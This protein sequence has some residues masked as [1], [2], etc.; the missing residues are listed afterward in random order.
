MD[1]LFPYTTRFRAGGAALSGDRRQERAEQIA[2]RG[3]D[4]HAGEAG[5]ARGGRDAR[6][7][8]D[9]IDHLV[10][11]QRTRLRI[12]AEQLEL[13][14]RWRHRFARHVPR[15]LPP[16][17]GGL[18]PKMLAADHPVRAD[19]LSGVWGQGWSVLVDLCGLAF[20]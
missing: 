5:C 14:G 2:V 15:C 1:I 8:F 18:P 20:L 12:I 7:A 10:F 19:R 13:H 16:G 4:L 11:A 9:E 17:L 6:K 3:M